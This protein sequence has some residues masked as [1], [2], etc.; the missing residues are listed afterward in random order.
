[1]DYY[2]SGTI[3]PS[4]G[5][6]IDRFGYPVVERGTPII[7]F[8]ADTNPTDTERNIQ[9]LRTNRIETIDGTS[10]EMPPISLTS[11]TTPLV[12][13]N[14]DLELRTVSDGKV[15]LKDTGN[16]NYVEIEHDSATTAIKAL[17]P[18][19]T[20]SLAIQTHGDGTLFL[21]DDATANSLEIKHDPASSTIQAKNGGTDAGLYLI[22][23]NSGATNI[24]NETLAGSL[25]IETTGTGANLTAGGSGGN[26]EMKI[27]CTGTSPLYFQRQNIDGYL[28]MNLNPSQ[29]QLSARAGVNPASFDFVAKGTGTHIFRDDATSGALEI[30]PS[31]DAVTLRGINGV[32]PNCD[33]NLQSKGGGNTNISKPGVD[34]SVG[35]VC[36]GG[37]FNIYSNNPNTHSW[38]QL[39]PK[40]YGVLYAP[41]WAFYLYTTTGSQSISAATDTKVLFTQESYNTFPGGG[42]GLLSYSGTN[43]YTNNSP[44]TITVMITSS[45]RGI[46]DGANGNFEIWIQKNGVSD[47]YYGKTLIPA[48][49]GSNADIALNASSIVRLQTGESFSVF[50]RSSTAITIGTGVPS[51]VWRASL[52]SVR[53]MP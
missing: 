35:I 48:T 30:D 13:G 2:D 45:V 53:Y 1:M 39:I 11:V 44:D 42:A 38:I 17:N 23:K 33:L 29:V 7:G 41:N 10:L 50:V 31:A 20:A 34:G 3:D 4:T 21:R 8:P 27:V 6:Y 9:V 24:T 14:P 28:Q 18:N 15:R 25:K 51:E 52:L 43:T 22:T 49:A 5:M 26:G 12:V 46:F 37:G 32:G 16:A 47:F 19:P 40:G 36:V